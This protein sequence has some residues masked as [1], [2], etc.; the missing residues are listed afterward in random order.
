MIDGEA[1]SLDGGSVEHFG[2]ALF[3]EGAGT[4]TTCA[5]CH[6]EGGEDG[7]VWLFDVG[8]RRTQTLNGGI[9]TTAPFH[10]AGDVPDVTH[11][12]DGTF[13]GRMAGAMPRTDEVNA[14]AEW[15]N[16]LPALPGLQ[17]EAGAI[18]R[19][20]AAFD[21]GGCASCHSG[22]LRTNNENVDVGTGGRFNVPA[23]YEVV[24]HA[25]YF[26]DGSMPTLAGL[27][28]S[29]GDGDRLSTTERADVVTYLRSL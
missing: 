9:M 18:V 10:W 28:S 4:G 24:Y 21:S 20:R 11:V 23:L 1:I 15:M 22:E 27:V 12:L 5:S 29:H 14:F 17:G 16:D 6:P 8:R 7:H 13:V 3:H 2:H 26:H 25:P 19:G